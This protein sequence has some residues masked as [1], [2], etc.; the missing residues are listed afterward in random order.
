[1]V[2]QVRRATYAKVIGY[3]FNYEYDS[4]RDFRRAVDQRFGS[5]VPAL[6]RQDYDNPAANAVRLEIMRLWRGPVLQGLDQAE[7]SL[8]NYDD[9]D[10]ASIRLIDSGDW[11][12]IT[13]GSLDPMDA[14]SS[15][16]V[17]EI[18]RAKQFHSL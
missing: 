15:P 7:W 9:A 17:L 1:M 3:W 5:R 18:L 8:R 2:E 13:L 11:R 4:R 12:D 10:L 14:G 16:R 6:R